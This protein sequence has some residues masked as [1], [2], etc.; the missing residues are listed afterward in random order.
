MF[1]KL[2][3][4]VYRA[5][6]NFSK[7]LVVW[8]QNLH[9]FKALVLWNYGNYSSNTWCRTSPRYQR[10]CMV[11]FSINTK[12]RCIMTSQRGSSSFETRVEISRLLNNPASRVGLSQSLDFMRAKWLS[13]GEY[14]VSFWIY[15]FTGSKYRTTCCSFGKRVYLWIWLLFK[16]V[17]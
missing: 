5:L 7:V 1:S 10:F 17:L 13:C 15:Q 9:N 12:R 8:N 14:R 4:N 16:R 6:W 2:E 11:E 3:E